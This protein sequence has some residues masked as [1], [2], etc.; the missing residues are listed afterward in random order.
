MR[1]TTS[2]APRLGG[3]AAACALATAA[4][5]GP[6]AGTS[7]RPPAPSVS[8]GERAGE[9]AGDV[10]V[11]AAASLTDVL[12]EVAADLEAA[13]PG[14]TV[15]TAFGPSSGLAQQVLAGAPADVLVTAAPEPMAGVVAAGAAAG[16]PVVVARNHLQ[17]AVPPGNPGGV[18]GLADLADDDLVVALCDVQVP[19]GAAAARA[20]AAAG[21]A[22]APDTLERD[23][24]AVLTK[25]RL[26]EVDAGVVYRTNVLA[27]GDDVEGVDLPGPVDSAGV[28]EAV[29]LADARAPDLARAVVDHLLGEDG[30]RVLRDA[31][32]DLP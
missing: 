3:L 28:Y 17:I 8:G 23:V 30:R 10:V 13:H 14:L 25:V 27:A 4:C 12:G 16:E 2:R 6:S 19:C 21:V 11:L 22:P 32:F 5:V 1:P 29:V 20:F 26:G 24:R 18:T 9:L 15:T 31:G 7:A